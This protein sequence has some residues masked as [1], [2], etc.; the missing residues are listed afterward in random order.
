MS[1]HKRIARSPQV[2]TAHSAIVS[3]LCFE[4]L[5]PLLQQ[6]QQRLDRRLV[7]TFLAAILAILRHRHRPC[8]L[9]LSEL[10]AALL[11]PQRA[12]AGTKRLKR[13]L[14]AA[15]WSARLIDDFLAMHA[16]QR[17]DEL[18]AQGV[19]P[20]VVWD[21]SALE[22][23]ES[24]HLDGLGPVRSLKAARLKRIKPGYFN[25]PG[26]R[27]VFVPGFHWL[28]VLVLGTQGARA[29]DYRTEAQLLLEHLTHRWGH[30]VIHVWD[31]G[32]AGLPWLQWVM[33]WG[34]RFI[35]RWP[36]N[37]RLLDQQ[38]E[39]RKAWQ[40]TRGKRSWDHR[41]LYDARRR[42]Q[43]RV[44]IVAVSVREASGKRPLWLVVS[45]PGAGRPPWYLLTNEPIRSTEDAWRIVLAY[46]R[47]W[48]IE[49]LIR[50]EKSELALE[51]ARVYGWETWDKL[52]GLATLALAFLLSL[53]D[54]QWISLRD[55]LL[56]T[57]CHALGK[58]RSRGISAPLYRLRSALAHLWLAYPPPFLQRL[59]SG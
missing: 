53:L 15:R 4:F 30:R 40:L 22:K 44:G 43:R 38:G 8:G 24:L 13:L 58:K 29:R 47:R 52:L 33:Q 1:Q 59:N 12:A 9:L 18:T 31:R 35:L 2:Q 28:G 54:V 46:A 49:L 39:L 37:Y 45:R 3:D 36:K 10:G 21:E 57:W 11:T 56:V 51:S 25:P 17:V 14:Y 7:C 41:L 20:L 16:D 48:Q 50:V 34:T 55:W 6:L 5:H 19:T 27:P 26:G 32:F 42:C 23:S